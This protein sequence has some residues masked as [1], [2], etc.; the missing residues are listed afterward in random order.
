MVQPLIYR[1]SELVK[2]V[3]VSKTTIYELI[4]RGDFPSPVGLTG[5]AVGWRA[6]EIERWVGTRAVVLK[7][8]RGEKTVGPTPPVGD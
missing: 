6:S 7:G 5:K 3:G 8:V 4:A 2:I 1:I